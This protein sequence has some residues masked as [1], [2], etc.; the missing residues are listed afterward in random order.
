[1]ALEMMR[2]SAHYLLKKII[3]DFIIAANGVIIGRDV[4]SQMARPTQKQGAAQS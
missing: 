1:M 4:T 3:V 2:V